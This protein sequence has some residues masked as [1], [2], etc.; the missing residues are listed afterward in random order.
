[1]GLKRFLY[2]WIHHDQNIRKELSRLRTDVIV[3]R[4]EVCEAI[5]DNTLARKIDYLKDKT[6]NSVDVGVSSERYCQNEIIVSLTSHGQRIYDVY[7]AIES[8]MQGSM[9]PNRILLWLSEEEFGQSP[10][11]KTL[12]LQKERGVEIRYCKDIK[13][14]K[15]LIPALA[16]FPQACII[17][18]DDDA[19]YEFDILERLLHAHLQS[20]GAICS[21]RMHK[22]KLKDNGQPMSYLDWDQC[23]DSCDSS[24]LCF[25]TTGGGTLY[26]PNCFS[27]EVFNENSFMTLCP[28]AD[29]VWFYSMGVINRTPVVKVKTP[30]P[31]GYYHELPTAFTNALF[32]K[33][34][35]PGECR[36]DRQIEAVFS[37]YRIPDYY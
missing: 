19:I 30:N 1:M 22:I 32:L 34:E 6:L 12:L 15:K 14:Y 20:P 26:P 36:N 28:Y 3:S 33:N 7:L 21:C 24:P 11:P 18:I 5:K 13:S 8:I 2:N 16:E 25:P 23:V 29:D 27:Q 10:L 17:T 31:K 4:H 35:D 37:K 9:K